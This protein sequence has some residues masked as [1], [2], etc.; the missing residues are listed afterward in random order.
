MIRLAAASIALAVL[1]SPAAASDHRIAFGDL[2]L[3]SPEGVARFDRR[4]DRAARSACATGSR[5]AERL[6]LTDFRAAALDGLPSALLR[7]YARGRA[8]TML[9]RAPATAR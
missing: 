7:E 1:A 4:L 8:G 3:G 6:C 9:V 5:H 2:D